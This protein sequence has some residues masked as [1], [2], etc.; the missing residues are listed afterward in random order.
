MNYDTLINFV[1]LYGAAI[2]NIIGSIVAFAKNTKS[3]KFN[4]SLID[5]AA[6]VNKDFV[7]IKKELIEVKKMNVELQQNCDKLTEEIEKLSFSITKIRK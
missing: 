5:A 2:A 7:N 4:S 6:S 3:L 1:V